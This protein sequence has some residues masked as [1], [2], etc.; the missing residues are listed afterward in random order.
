MA[1]VVKNLPAVQES[2]I[3]S[4]GW[5]DSLEKRKA[6]HSREFHG[7][8]SPWG[9]KEFGHNWASR[10]VRLLKKLLGYF[11]PTGHVQGLEK[12]LWLFCS[13]SVSSP[14]CVWDGF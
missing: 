2:W 12:P 1:Q 4:L 13:L 8:Y 10:C 6:T 5:K 14:G 3:Q 9:H 11:V 7:L